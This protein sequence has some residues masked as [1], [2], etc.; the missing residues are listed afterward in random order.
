MI[1]ARLILLVTGT[2][3]AATIPLLAHASC[4]GNFQRMHVGVLP[5]VFIDPV[6]LPAFDFTIDPVTGVPRPLFLSAPLQHFW[7]GNPTMPPAGDCNLWAKSFQMPN[8]AISVT[9]G[10]ANCPSPPTASELHLCERALAHRDAV[11]VG[12]AIADNIVKKWPLMFSMRAYQVRAQQRQIG[13]V[14]VFGLDCAGDLCERPTCLLETGNGEYPP[15]VPHP[16]LP[17]CRRFDPSDGDWRGA[18]QVGRGNVYVG[19]KRN[20]AFR[21]TATS[22]VTQLPIDHWIANGNP[23]ARIFI[24]PLT[25]ATD[26]RRHFFGVK[27]DDLLARWVIVAERPEASIASG[28]AFNVYVMGDQGPSLRVKAKSDTTSVVLSDPLLDENPAAVVLA[29]HVA[30]GS[31]YFDKPYSVAYDTRIRRWKI[32]AGAGARFNDTVFNVFVSGLPG[33]YRRSLRTSDSMPDYDNRLQPAPVRVDPFAP[34]PPR[35]VA[36]KGNAI[37][38]ITHNASPR[39]KGRAMATTNDNPAGVMFVDGQWRVRN[40]NGAPMPDTLYNV[41]NPLPPR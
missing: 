3:I 25:S 39:L 4:G 33:N 6:N 14:Q 26:T 32:V 36:G 23:S 30:Y 41:L 37:V 9:Y 28:E 40:L 20:P 2:V 8:L 10:A 29:T 21:V 5:D 19:P 22:S 27:Y 35:L 15:G 13:G 16:G 34:S 18:Y 12:P 38:L 1:L 31:N 24:T 11:T 7:T 17:Q